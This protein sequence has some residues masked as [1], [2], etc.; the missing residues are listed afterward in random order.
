[1]VNNNTGNL[2][3]NRI[4]IFTTSI[5]EGLGIIILNLVVLVVTRKIPIAARNQLRIFNAFLAVSDL[6][7]G[8][9]L[10]LEAIT[11]YFKD[12]ELFHYYY[13]CVSV[14]GFAKT[15]LTT[16]GYLL[17]WILIVKCFSIIC[18]L[19]SLIFVTRQMAIRSSVGVWIFT[20]SI[21]IVPFFFWARDAVYVPE[22]ECDLL[23]VFHDKLTQWKML[24]TCI[25]VIIVAGCLIL[26]F[27]IVVKIF[28]RN[29]QFGNAKRQ[30]DTRSSVPQ[31]DT[32]TL[33]DEQNVFTSRKPDVTN[34]KEVSNKFGRPSYEQKEKTKEIISNEKVT[35]WK[36]P[37]K[38][39]N[40]KYYLT[41]SKSFKGYLIVLM[42]VG[43]QLLTTLPITMFTQNTH[44][45]VYY[46]H[47]RGVRFVCY[48][49]LCL[50]SL[51]N[52]TVTLLLLPI[53]KTT[54]TKLCKKYF[55]RKL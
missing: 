15:Q 10:L 12:T 27:L 30:L 21:S 3:G 49:S 35:R 31:P 28:L 16:T 7:N 47:D 29:R 41:K 11:F 2:L 13:I 9:I 25:T 46:L 26:N 38:S 6:L 20:Y 52:P 23:M 32:R 1:M 5:F 18:P 17:L 48:M 50:T 22:E 45:S 36:Y 24:G 34:L 43:F 40:N 51:F 8:G 37:N 42:N 55:K 19:Q 54:L 4:F 53:Y 14:V 33:K 44:L 39:G